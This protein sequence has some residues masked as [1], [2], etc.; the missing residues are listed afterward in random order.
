MQNNSYEM[1]LNSNHRKAGL[2]GSLAGI[3]GGGRRRVEN[4]LGVAQIFSVI[5]KFVEGD[6]KTF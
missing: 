2:Q 5:A 6:S 4:F 1:R 3:T